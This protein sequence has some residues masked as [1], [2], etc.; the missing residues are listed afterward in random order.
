MNSQSEYRNFGCEWCDSSLP[1]DMYLGRNWPLL[2]HCRVLHNPIQLLWGASSI[3]S[4][5]FCEHG[6]TAIA[7]YWAKT[8]TD[9]TR[10]HQRNDKACQQ[11]TEFCQSGWPDKK[12]LSVTV[13]PYFPTAAE[14]SVEGGLLVRGSRIVIPPTLCKEL[15]DKIHE[16]HQG[17]TKCRERARQSLWWPGLSKELVWTCT[18]CCKAQKQTAQPMTPSPLSKLPWQVVRTDLFECN[19][20]TFLLIVHTTPGSSRSLDWIDWQRMKWSHEL[21]VFSH[22]MEYL[23]L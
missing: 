5:C 10:Q 20:A 17:I 6:A 15:L 12:S 11:I 7:C 21:R 13:R 14:F 8:R 1:S 23:K 18:K 4:K 3:G 19:Q 2:I 9:Q 16:G 22:G